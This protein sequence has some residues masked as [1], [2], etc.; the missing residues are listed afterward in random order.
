MARQLSSEEISKT[1]YSSPE[2]FWTPPSKKA[3]KPTHSSTWK[4][5]NRR[6][7]RSKGKCGS[8]YYDP[9]EGDIYFSRG[10][11][12]TTTNRFSLLENTPC[13]GRENSY[14][15]S[16]DTPHGRR[17]PDCAE[18]QERLNIFYN[19]FEDFLYNISKYNSVKYK[20]DEYNVYLC[21]NKYVFVFWLF[22]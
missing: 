5:P 7:P 22:S 4:A 15:R 10:G 18:R 1:G 14:T 20:L 2:G 9:V 8:Y 16:E 21:N 12:I 6:N 17:P 11:G 13:F 3:V 19:S